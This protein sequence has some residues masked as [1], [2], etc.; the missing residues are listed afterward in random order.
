[1]EPTVNELRDVRRLAESLSFLTDEAL[2]TESLAATPAMLEGGRGTCP[3]RMV[4]EAFVCRSTVGR[5]VQCVARHLRH[6]RY[7]DGIGVLDDLTVVIKDNL[8]VADLAMTAG[9]ADFSFVP[10][11]DPMVITR[12]LGASATLIGKANMDAF[13]FGSTGEFSDFGPVDNP[14]VDGTVPGGS[15]SGSAVA[16][17]A[18]LVDAALGTDTGGSVRQPPACCGLVG[19]TPTH[20]F[21]P[22]HGLMEFT[23]STDTIGPMARDVVTA[24]GVLEVIAG[25]RRPTRPR[26][27]STS[28]R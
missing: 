13:A 21:G 16:V 11:F 1:M 19:V 23:L 2:L 12:L 14:V 20:R 22:R 17:V 25:H 7:G 9:L 18:G 5:R 10:S 27:G 3:I 28:S 26:A 15:S 24:A 4:L 6:P 8:A